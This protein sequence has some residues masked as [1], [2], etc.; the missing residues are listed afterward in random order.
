ME[1]DHHDTNSYEPAGL[2]KLDLPSGGW[3]AFNDP[4]DLRGSDVK[5]LMK[6]LDAGAEGTSINRL[7]D[8]AMALLIAEWEI[9]YEPNLPIPRY[10]RP[11]SRSTATDRLKARD[12]NAIRD[13]LKPTVQDLTRGRD[14]GDPR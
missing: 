1:P 10:D 2:D 7:Y 14:D 5:K 4:D 8:E 9:P 11:G 12:Y 6:C 13:H 3:V